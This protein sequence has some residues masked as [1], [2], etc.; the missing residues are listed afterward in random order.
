M[1][2]QATRAA[3]A[4]GPLPDTD[5]LLLKDQL[6]FSLYAA[7]RALTRLYRDQLSPLG[8][9]YPQFLVLLV[10]WEVGTDTVSGIGRRLDLDSGTLTPLLKRLE[11]AGFVTRARTRADE[12]EVV[13]SLT[14]AGRSIRPQVQA[15]R[16]EVVDRLGLDAGAIAALRDGLLDLASRLGS[17]GPDGPEVT[18]VPVRVSPRR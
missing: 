14:E 16:C 11:A 7:S 2:R 5:G 4:T 15:A 13:V 18:F 12:R 8:L 6:C 9:T 1:A 3:G 10:L 17:D